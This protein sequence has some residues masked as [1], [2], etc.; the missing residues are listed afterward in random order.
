MKLAVAQMALSNNFEN[1]AIKIMEF[2]EWASKQEVELL[3]FPEMSL[4]GYTEALLS[5]SELN[6]IIGEA[7]WQIERKCNEFN[8]G[9][10]IGYGYREDPHLFNRA[11]V[12]LPGDEH[13]TY[14][15]IYLTEL[16]EKYF[17]GGTDT[18]VFPFQESRIGVIIC[19]DQNYPLLT[20]ELKEKGADYI[21][22]LSAHYYKP[23]EARWKLD[24]NRA[25]PI[26]RAVEN[27]VHV[28]LSNTVG[29]HLGMTSLGNSLIADPDG[30]VV[31][32]A[33]EH[34]EGL[35]LLSTNDFVW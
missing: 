1:N 4:T 10:I 26:A 25:L 29:T 11:G 24:K 30:A 14:D 32:S 9:V 35:L 12:I 19:R 3:C 33:D 8:L 22:I 28:L 7:L 23:K 2:M 34:Q 5:R 20:K 21:F 13:F 27:K 16:E 18:L 17:Q 15:K 31:V 6:L